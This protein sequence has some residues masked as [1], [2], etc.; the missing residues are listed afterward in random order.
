V[1]VSRIVAPLFV[2]A[3]LAAVGLVPDEA[4][5][6]PKVAWTEALALTAFGFAALHL[7]LTASWRLPWPRTTITGL[8]PLLLGLGWLLAGRLGSLSLAEDEV[9]RVALFSIVFWTVAVSLTTPGLRRGAMVTLVCVTIPVAGLAVGQSLAGVLDLPFDRVARASSTFGNPVFLGAF[10]VLVT[11]ICAAAALFGGGVIRWI[12]GLATG[13]ALPALLATQSRWAWLGGAAGVACGMG[14]LATTRQHR[15]MLLGG[16]LVVAIVLAALSSKVLLRPQNHAL[17]WRD[18]AHMVA[19]HPWGVGP[20]QFQVAFLPF[21]S[22]ELLAVY[23]R[24]SVIVNDAH[25]EPLQI[26]AELGWPGLLAVAAWLSLLVAACVRHLKSLGQDDPERPILAALMA[27]LLGSTVQSLGSPDLRFL[28][29]SV[30]FATLAGMAAAMDQ[31]SGPTRPVRWPARL[32]LT[33]A[34]LFSIG[35]AGYSIS[36]HSKLAALLQPRVPSITSALA[37]K[38]LRDL[39]NDVKGDPNN[40]ELHYNIG[41]ALAQ[42]KRYHE[43]AIAFRKAATLSSGRASVLHSLAIVEGLGGEFEAAIPHLRA[44]LADYPDDPKLRYLLAYSAYGLGDIATAIRELEA[45]LSTHP[46]HP[47]GRLLLEKLRE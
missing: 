5:F 17:I 24:S 3:T 31:S 42:S 9:A 44:S 18:T 25:C 27:G 7:A 11:P 2:A 32:L 40:A 41:V 21:A 14:L 30:M 33:A 16:L 26:L 8:I 43:A 45:L 19:E 46:D 38:P 6:R 1:R 29:S 12:G 22:P 37:T 39:F 23:P 36:E 10:L 13:L 28:I 34:G 15:R 47:Q 4:V 35:W 20:G